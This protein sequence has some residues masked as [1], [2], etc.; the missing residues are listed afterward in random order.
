MLRV[1]I[2][3]RKI[4]DY[5]IGTYIRG[6]LGGFAAAPYDDIEFVLFA[7][8]AGR[9]LIPPHPRFEVIEN[10]SSHYSIR[11]IYSIGRAAERAGVDVLHAPHYVTPVTSLPLVTTIHDLIH[12]GL[13]PLWHP[14]KA[15]YARVMI[16]RAVE[17]SRRIVT[18][19]D[20]VKR[21]IAHRYLAALDKI[22]AIPNG[23]DWEF[24]QPPEDL[25]RVLTRYGLDAQRYF[26]FV[27]NDKPHKN[28][29]RL[30]AAFRMVRAENALFSLAI[31]GPQRKRF[32]NVEGV[33]ETGF[34][35]TA[36]LAAI[37]RGAIAL[38]QPSLREGFGLPVAEAMA[39]GTPVII[40][41]DPALEEV[42]GPRAPRVDARSVESIADGMRTIA[43]D[44]VL[45][46][47]LARE[48]RERA[49]GFSW[50]ECARATMDVYRAAVSG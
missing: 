19:T 39:S 46:E 40:S 20:A 41:R 3:C 17:R 27:G 49:S 6:L 7:A 38:V 18:V 42:A 35:P 33:I 22:V 15:I 37:Q 28:L 32:K 13:S 14:A 4:A 2:D 47:R 21:E 8:A 44:D 24:L 16:G 43:R 12:L 48:V 31:V 25:E 9:R 29:D 45:R 36:D 30:V 5:G 26:L 11:E 1:G 34:V 50:S 23:V 10:E